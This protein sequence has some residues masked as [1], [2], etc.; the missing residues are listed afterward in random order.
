[1]SFKALTLKAP[2][3]ARNIVFPVV[4]NQSETLCQ[5]FGLD[6]IEADV[7]ALLDTGATNTSISD[8]LAASLGLKPVG[9]YK[10]EAAGGVHMAAAYSI[11]VL[12]RNMVSFTN[13]R[14]AAF[15]KNDQFDIIIGMDIIT[16]GDLAITNANNRTVVSFRVPPDTEHIDYVKNANQNDSG[17]SS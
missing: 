4:I 8:T 16:L 13:I 3:I 1:M 12:F 2:G 5:K 15:V 6:K 11:D 9:R 17:S 7:Y 10:V 14:S